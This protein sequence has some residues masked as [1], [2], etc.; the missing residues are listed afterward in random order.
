MGTATPEI[1]ISQS[2]DGITIEQHRPTVTGMLAGMGL[3]E[4]VLRIP[5]LLPICGNAQSI[6]AQRAAA[7]AL[8]EPEPYAAEHTRQLWREQALAAAWRLA[9]DWPKLIDKPHEIALLKAAQGAVDPAS[10]ATQLLDLIPGLIG[11]E[12]GEDIENWMKKSRCTA[13]QVVRHAR[14]IEVG[15]E[16]DDSPHLAAA[17]HLHGLALAALTENP[18]NPLEPGGAGGLEVGPLAMGRHPFIPDLLHSE[19][20]GALSRRLVAQ[21]VDTLV[22]AGHLLDE[23][24]TYPLSA[25]PLGG[26]EGLGRAMTARGPVFHRVAVGDGEVV[27]DWR[28]LAPTDWHFAPDGPLMRE[29]NR[30]KLN[31]DQLR[32]LVAGFDPCAPWTVDSEEAAHA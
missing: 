2:G 22:I 31:D 27:K 19:R 30:L 29:A 6:A 12:T 16:V 20:F 9:I 25:W 5:L 7:G 26:N 24:S 11:A 10:L 17:D 28:V 15:L 1:R 13:A 3:E 8:G 14:L 21:L 32:F 23:K 4:A 18:F